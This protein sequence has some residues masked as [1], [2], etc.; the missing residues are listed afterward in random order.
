MRF[1]LSPSPVSGEKISKRF[2]DQYSCA[3]TVVTVPGDLS[4]TTLRKLLKFHKINVYKG[5]SS[6]GG[7]TGFQRTFHQR[8]WEY[9]SKSSKIIENQKWINMIPN[10]HMFSRKVC[11]RFQSQISI[12]KFQF[13]DELFQVGENPY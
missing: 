2:K 3:I 6:E 13:L 9:R 5:W 1:L 4:I 10:P 8:S 12:L 7:N 11:G